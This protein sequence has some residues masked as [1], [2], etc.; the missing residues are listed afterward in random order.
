[1]FQVYGV[2][3]AS[4]VQDKFCFVNIARAE[5]QS[6]SY[7]VREADTL[8]AL[9]ECEDLIDANSEDLI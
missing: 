2:D 1:M 5:E 6:V 7:L 4:I 8:W 9:L 3:A